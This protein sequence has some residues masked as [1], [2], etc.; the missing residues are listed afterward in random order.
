MQSY[1]LQ[2]VGPQ[3]V[4]FATVADLFV[5]ESGAATGGTDT[6]IMVK[7]DTGAEIVLRPGQRFRIDKAS[8]KATRWQVH[9]FDPAV[10]ITG[11]II[12]GS[13]EF[14]DANTLNKFTL[15][16]SLA[17]NVTVMNT[18]AARVPVT[19]DTTQII[20]TSGGVIAYQKSY[21]MTY[22]ALGQ[23]I[24]IVTA[25]QN[26]N[27][28]MVNR[29]SM[30]GTATPSGVEAAFIA[31]AAVPT[32]SADGDVI[33]WVPAIPGLYVDDAQIKIP[34]GRGLWLINGGVAGGSMKSILYTIL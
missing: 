9:A 22:L 32:G 20:Q 28:I 30:V 16:A 33:A 1:V 21:N 3:V 25:A 11:S 2:L 17:N 15:D 6:R 18:A 5:Y 7:P 13:G 29:T 27:G 10:T 26:V 19:L 31:N 8:K 24:N 23:V 12:I 4:P 14:D 34:A